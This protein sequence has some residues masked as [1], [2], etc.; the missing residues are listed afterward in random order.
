MLQGAADGVQRDDRDAG[1]DRVRHE[2]CRALVAVDLDE[3]GTGWAVLADPEGN[4]FCVVRSQ[5]ERDGL[6][7]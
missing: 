7:E 4:E 2:P 5:A 1:C 3:D 6:R